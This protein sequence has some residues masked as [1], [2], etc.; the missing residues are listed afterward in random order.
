MF[1]NG[2]ES[3]DRIGKLNLILCEYNFHN[4]RHTW[5]FL[6]ESLQIDFHHQW[7]LFNDEDR[8]NVIPRYLRLLF[9]LI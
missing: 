9:R 3:E 2:K 4:I 8:N 5:I 7:G 6:S 1:L